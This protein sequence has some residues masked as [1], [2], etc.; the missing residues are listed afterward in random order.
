[1]AMIVEE[2]AERG[3]EFGFGGRSFA[4]EVSGLA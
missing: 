1:M 2:A 4:Y 3:E